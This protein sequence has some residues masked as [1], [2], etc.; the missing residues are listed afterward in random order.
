MR[1]A[2]RTV[3]DRARE[4]LLSDAFRHLHQERES[5][6][7]LQELHVP[8]LVV[9]PGVRE[10]V[11]HRHLRI[12][13]RDFDLE[14]GEAKLRHVLQDVS[15][16]VLQGPILLVEGVVHSEQ[17]EQRRIVQLQDIFHFQ[18]VQ[19]PL[20]PFIELHYRVE[21]RQNVFFEQFLQSRGEFVALPT[22]PVLLIGY[23]QQN[24]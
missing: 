6:D 9:L 15:H 20:P 24:L 1:F 12:A 16:C 17:F 2:L 13:V 3:L 14:L 21:V 7:E 22:L 18:P 4:H 23:S 5:A 11:H 19:V 10:L 8:H